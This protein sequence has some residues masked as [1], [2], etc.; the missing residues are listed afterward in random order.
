MK[1]SL[2]SLVVFIS[3]MLTHALRAQGQVSSQMAEEIRTALNS[4]L[5]P[6]EPVI[7]PDECSDMSSPDSRVQS[8]W[9]RKYTKTKDSLAVAYL[10]LGI[11]RGNS[12]VHPEPVHDTIVTGIL[13][14]LEKMRGVKNHKNE[15]VLILVFNS[16]RP[17][18]NQAPMGVVKYEL[19][20]NG[21]AQHVT[22]SAKSVQGSTTTSVPVTSSVQTVS[23]QASSAPQGVA[24]NQV[25]ELPLG[26]LRVVD[27]ITYV[28]A[29]K[30]VDGF[31]RWVEFNAVKTAFAQGGSNSQN[32]PARVDTTARTAHYS[33][34]VSQSGDPNLLASVGSQGGAT[35]SNGAV[36]ANN[37][38][39]DPTLFF[40]EVDCETCPKG[41]QKVRWDADA[42]AWV[43]MDNLQPMTVKR[44]QA[45]KNVLTDK[46]EEEPRA[47][48]N[49]EI[50][51]YYDLKKDRPTPASIEQARM[52]G[53]VPYCSNGLWGWNYVGV[54]PSSSCGG[55][56]HN[57]NASQYRADGGQAGC[58]P[59]GYQQRDA[60]MPWN[61][62]R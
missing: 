38:R 23:G 48:T 20:G 52:D 32:Q 7:T 16:G 6:G 9:F 59:T 57:R 50:N 18:G 1:K 12:I 2:F 58:G 24:S 22:A 55:G 8:R 46:I 25:A 33:L 31:P 37:E 29:G 30:D 54:G 11:Q 26:E 56:F 35:K 41:K 3:M 51:H 49:K 45:V 40:R 44:N 21:V 43:P 13:F 10:E 17:K 5:L 28:Y 34:D 39:T 61:L 62:R 36:T 47:T 15:D 27:G 4:H 53:Y 19:G 14:R 42:R 60:Q